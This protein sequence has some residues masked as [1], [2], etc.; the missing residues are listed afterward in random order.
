MEGEVYMRSPNLYIFRDEQLQLVISNEIENSLPLLSCRLKEVIN[1]EVSLSF[2]IPSD[3]PDSQ[4][5]REG[6]WVIIR[7]MDGVCRP[8]VII[9]ENE[10]HDEN[11]IREFVTEELAINELNDEIVTDVRPQ[12]TTAQD[13]LTRILS[14]AG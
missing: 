1:G 13:A 2:S 9:E 10:V 3:H 4:Y 5:I 6:C 8:F 7:D 12:D 11:L 14:N